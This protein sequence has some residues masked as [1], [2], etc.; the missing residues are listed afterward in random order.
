M[1]LE[2][3]ETA[4]I[5]DLNYRLQETDNSWLISIT[6]HLEA[7]VGITKPRTVQ[8]LLTVQIEDVTDA[9]AKRYI[10]IQRTKNGEFSE[11]LSLE[12]P[13]VC[14][15]YYLKILFS[16]IYRK[17]FSSQSQKVVANMKSWYPSLNIGVFLSYVSP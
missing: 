8:G 16:P 2:V 7:G 4:I 3:Y 15:F 13:K 11:N 14:M 17:M 10:T 6:V 9:T 5:R 12:I 1:I